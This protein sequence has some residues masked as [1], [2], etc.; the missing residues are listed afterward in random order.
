M[1]YRIRLAAS[2]LWEGG[3][4][5]Y[6]TEGV[7][8]LGCLPDREEA[9][10]RIL[11]IKRR[12]PE[13][14]LILVAAT[15]EQL[16]PFMGDLPGHARRAMAETWPGPVT[17]VVPAAPDVPEQLT[18]GRETIAVRVSDHPVVQALCRAA[19]SALISTSANRSGQPPAINA[20][21]A[22][23]RFG[24]EVDEV[25]PGRVGGLDGPTEI[26][27]ALSGNILRHGAKGAPE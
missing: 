8:G 5:A 25:V 9:I 12:A 7:W 11:D 14:G 21:Q 20:R 15:M 4:I 24:L 6:P 10:E 16:E 13:K 22:R 3:V 18:G 2:T 1:D 27:D 17:W 23:L 19:D 26:R